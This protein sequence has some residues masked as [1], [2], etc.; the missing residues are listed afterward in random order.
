MKVFALECSAVTAATAIVEDGRIL[1]SNFLKT[2]LTHSE[3]IMPMSAE[4]FEKSGLKPSD[5]DLFA[6]SAGPG[7]F[8]GLR[9]GIATLKGLAFGRD[10]KCCAVSTLKAIAYN[11][12][13][14]EATVVCAMDARR[15]Q[16][17]TATFK[18]GNSSVKR[19]T[20]DE[21]VPAIS[22]AG[23]INTYS[24]KVIIA[25]DGAELTYNI[26]KD[27]CPNIVLAREEQ[28]YQNA[29]G[30]AKC[31]LDETEYINAEQLVPTYIRL[32]QAVR[33][34]NNKKKEN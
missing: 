28:M 10:V 1:H 2:G 3:T 7:S 9:I 32:P 34:L 14:T 24:G 20:D 29:V 31:A 6:V 25:G 19:L 12:D 22:L 30:V 17:Y 23:R 26:L 18:C 5:I 21:A 16:I 8:T 33:E 15:E 11:F 27:S 13:D 4:T